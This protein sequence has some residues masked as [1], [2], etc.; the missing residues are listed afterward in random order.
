MLAGTPLHRGHAPLA[1]LVEA[2][3][4]LSDP[5]LALN[6]VVF[7]RRASMNRENAWTVLHKYR[8]VMHALM[9]DIHLHGIVEADEVYIG[10]RPRRPGVSRRGRGTAQESVLILVERRKGGHVFFKR[11]D[12]VAAATL[13]PPILA[14]V[15]CPSTIRTDG[16]PSY[17]RLRATGY[18]HAAYNMSQLPLPAHVYLPAVHGVSANAKRWMLEAQAARWT[19]VSVTWLPAP[20]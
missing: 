20:R 19:P 1:Q 13:R 9:L 16:N 3:W 15:R 4:L 2:A 12:T 17:N 8:E 7:E 11:L 6:A 18:R 5:Q 14:H 10:G